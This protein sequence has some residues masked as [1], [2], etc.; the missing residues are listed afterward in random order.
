MPITNFEKSSHGRSQG[1]TK[2]FRAPIHGAHRAVIFAIAQLSCLV[3]F[4]VF[5]CHVFN[6]LVFIVITV[7]FIVILLSASVHYL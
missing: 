3:F 4:R 7:Y 5:L 1:L 2:F 6:P